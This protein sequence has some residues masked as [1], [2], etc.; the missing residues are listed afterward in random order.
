[1][2]HGLTAYREQKYRPI[3]MAETISHSPTLLHL[4]SYYLLLQSLI[5]LN[6][7]YAALP[8]DA[9]LRIVLCLSAIILP[10]IL[11]KINENV[12]QQHVGLGILGCVSL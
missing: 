2:R 12:C 9:E 3:T 7:Y 6:N 4:I 11:C 8:I 1:M 5:L 10:V